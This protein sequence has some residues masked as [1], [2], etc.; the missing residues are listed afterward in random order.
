[1]AH[2]ASAKKRIRQQVKRRARNRM[3]LGNLRTRIRTL[4]RAIGDDDRRLAESLLP[5]AVKWVDRAATKGVIHKRAASRT[6]SRLTRAVDK[7]S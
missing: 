7:M 4:R 5:E 3:V 6:V 1:M 2:H